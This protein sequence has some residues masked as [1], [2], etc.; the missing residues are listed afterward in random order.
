MRDLINSVLFNDLEDLKSATARGEDPNKLNEFGNCALGVAI[1]SNSMKCLEELLKHP[2][3]DLN[4]KNKSFGHTP[5]MG[6]V[7]DKKFNCV[8]LL[9]EAGADVNCVSKSQYTPLMESCSKKSFEMASYLI[10]NKA[11]LD[12]IGE[13][14][15]TAFLI[16]IQNNMYD[17]FN[18]MLDKKFNIFY[19]HGNY[20][21]AVHNICAVQNE[22]MAKDLC[23][24]AH[25]M[26]QMQTV[27]THLGHTKTKYAK[28]PSSFYYYFNSMVNSIIM[29]DSLQVLNKDVEKGLKRG[30]KL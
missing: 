30:L 4:T 6:A 10:D 3:I 14:G 1:Q 16:A 25:E 29:H 2:A 5:L 15:Y 7:F 27:K 11:D 8:K 26:G 17:I 20:N 12:F 28:E 13:V 23:K 9:V 24:K 19:E 21:G 18:L 22:Q